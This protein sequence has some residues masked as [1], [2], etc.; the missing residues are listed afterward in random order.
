MVV[1]LSDGEVSDHEFGSDENGNFFAF[2]ATT[3]VNESDLVKENP[4]NGE[5]SKCADLQEAYD[6]LCKVVTKDAMSADLVLKK[7]ATLEHEKKNFLLNLLDTN[8]LV[9][10]V[11]A[12][13]IMLLDKIKNLELELPIVREQ[14]N[15]YTSSKLDHMLSIQK[16]PLEKSGLGFVDSIFVSETHF[17]NFVPS[18]EPLKIEVVKPKE[19]VPAPRKIRVDLKESKPNSPI[20]PKD[21]KHDRPLWVCHFCGKAGHTRPNF[22]KLQVAKQANKQKVPVSQVQNP[23]VLIGELVKALNLYTNAE[24]AHLSNMNNNSKTKFASKRL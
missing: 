20:F 7:I 9:N 6:K 14:T 1:S 15:R 11:K 21:K 23:T 16:S 19:D 18:Y 24:V 2:T 10:K 8:E 4:S 17:S 22:F 3:V 12:E 5:L 13:N